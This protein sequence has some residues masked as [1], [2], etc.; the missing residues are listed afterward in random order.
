MIILAIKFYCVV[1]MIIN[2]V[3]AY[4]SSRY[5]DEVSPLLCWL[6]LCDGM[7]LIMTGGELFAVCAPIAIINILNLSLCWIKFWVF[8]ISTVGFFYTFLGIFISTCFPRLDWGL[9]PTILVV[10]VLPKIIILVL[11]YIDLQPPVVLPLLVPPVVLPAAL[12]VRLPP[13]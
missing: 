3:L 13:S 10:S 5:Q 8:V 7:V 6:R 9:L 11:L 2:V 4:F 12:P 1:M